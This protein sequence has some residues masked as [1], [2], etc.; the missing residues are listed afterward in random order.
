MNHH[1]TTDAIKRFKKSHNI[2]VCFEQ[3]C[4]ESEHL[5]AIGSW[6]RKDGTIGKQYICHE[7]N[8][9][10]GKRWRQ[11]DTGKLSYY[12]SMQRSID[13]IVAALEAQ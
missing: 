2:P 6:K 12:R 1:T 8:A 3:G 11:T 4:T 7:H 10:R 5:I 9:A 13:K